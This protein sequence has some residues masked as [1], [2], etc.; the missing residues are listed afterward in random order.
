MGGMKGHGYWYA[1]DWI[2]TDIILSLRHPLPP[3]RRCLV[4]SRTRGRSGSFLNSI[5][6][7]WPTG[8]SRRSPICADCRERAGRHG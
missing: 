6:S 2:S 1:N 3:A 7:A 5:P 8:Y 4:K